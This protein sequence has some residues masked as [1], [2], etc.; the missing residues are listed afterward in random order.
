M[1]K[2]SY[3]SGAASI[4]LIGII[5]GQDTSIRA[6]W[7]LS[8]HDINNSRS[9]PLETRISPATA[10]QLAVKWSFTTGG[11]VSATPTVADNTVYLPDWGGNLY[12]LRADTGQQIWS[13]KISSY[14]G[15]GQ[16]GVVSRVSPSIFQDTLILG[17]NVTASQQHDGAH[18]FA[19]D[20]A[21]GNLR[22]ITQV[23]PHPAAVITSH[24]QISGN[25][26]YLGVSSNKELI[27]QNDAYM[28][29][30]F[31]GS[32]V[33]LNALTGAVLWKTFV[34]PD[35]QGFPTGYS[36]NAV[37][38]PPAIDEGR[39]LLYV[40]TG[41]NYTV[42]ESVKICQQA[43]FADPTQTHNCTPPDNYLDSA[44]ALDLKTGRVKWTQRV[45]AY[46]AWT[47]ACIT[48]PAP[49]PN[50]PAPP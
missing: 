43:P 25:V 26:V 21:T 5:T 50:C 28:C 42:P 9:Q 44:L 18:V 11:D 19:V 46:D 4:L 23:D 10:N 35:N 24:P 2:L 1:R 22:W 17:D 3:L 30:T 47:V 16:I 38:Q 49:G 13:R 37:W 14:T 27:A 15:I 31:R 41:N 34:I 6:D 48:A 12:A 8:G 20:R 45:S 29:C 33:A 40:G 7:T 32:V 39:G 36:G